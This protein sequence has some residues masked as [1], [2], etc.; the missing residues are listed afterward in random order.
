MRSIATFVCAFVV[1]L[2]LA[3]GA[4]AADAEGVAPVQGKW[5]ATTSAGLPLSF[6]VSGS[7]LVNARFRF[8][9]GF[10]GSFESALVS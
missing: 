5:H 7:Q 8:K 3:F 4:A 10:C 6:E 2:V 1:V 9:W